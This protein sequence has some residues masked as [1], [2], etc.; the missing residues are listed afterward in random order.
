MCSFIL[1]KSDPANP[2][3]L[4][5]ASWLTQ[6]MR[7]Y[8]RISTLS[9]PLGCVRVCVF[10]INFMRQAEDAA[11][12]CPWKEPCFSWLKI[13]FYS[14]NVQVKVIFLTGKM[15][16]CGC[17]W[18]FF[19]FPLYPLSLV[20][21]MPVSSSYRGLISVLSLPLTELPAPSLLVPSAPSLILLLWN[22]DSGSEFAL[23]PW[24]LKSSPL[25][26]RWVPTWRIRK[27]V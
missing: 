2:E 11:L 9:R 4:V 7:G 27:V 24:P 21:L 25:K 10:Q 18:I 15:L 1:L 16:S 20:Q 14:L 23:R 22:V 19:F 3:S 26:S 8:K 17:P 12:I 6:M 5:S 13:Y